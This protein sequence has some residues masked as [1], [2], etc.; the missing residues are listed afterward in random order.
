MV[1]KRF[2]YICRAASFAR[3]ADLFWT[4]TLRRLYG[5]TMG[6]DTDAKWNEP[7]FTPQINQKIWETVW[8]L[9]ELIHTLASGTLSSLKN[10]PLHKKY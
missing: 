9:S 4:A 6:A 7:N 5:V 2:A 3:G 1:R 8:H 10:E